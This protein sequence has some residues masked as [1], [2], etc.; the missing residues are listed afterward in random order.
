MLFL[1]GPKQLFFED[2]AMNDVE[3]N[4][5]LDKLLGLTDDDSLGLFLGSA[6]MRFTP[7]I[8]GEPIADSNL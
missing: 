4:E 2:S 1:I 7:K 8:C 5:R 6:M 3:N